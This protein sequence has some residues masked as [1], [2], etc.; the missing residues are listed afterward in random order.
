[1]Q[2]IMSTIPIW[3]TIWHDAMTL[4][5]RKNT[6]KSIEQINAVIAIIHLH[7]RERDLQSGKPTYL[8]PANGSCLKTGSSAKRR[9]RP[10]PASI[11]LY[12]SCCQG[13]RCLTC[14]VCTAETTFTYVVCQSV[15]DT[16]SLCNLCHRFPHLPT[17]SEHWTHR[18]WIGWTGRTFLGRLRL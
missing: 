11:K 4:A 14:T 18:L 8:A 9:A 7:D 3:K 2:G 17:A 16:P 6:I 5:K 13:K 12:T 15:L 10:L 1:M